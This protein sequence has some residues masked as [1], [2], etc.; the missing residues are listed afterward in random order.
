LNI[1][2]YI[3]K[4]IPLIII[5]LSIIITLVLALLKSDEEKDDISVDVPN[6]KPLLVEIVDFRIYVESAGHIKPKT[7]YPLRLDLPGKVVFLST[8]FNDNRIFNKGDTL[9]RID[10][11]DYSIARINAKFK[12]DE[13]ELEFLRQKAISS[14][15]ENELDEYKTTANVNDLAKNKPQLEKAKSLLNAAKANYRKTELDLKET[16]LVAP[17]QGRIIDGEANLGQDI[18]L[19]MY[20]G[21]IYSLDEMIIKLPL[22]IEDISILNLNHQTDFGQSISIQLDTRIGDAEYN[23]D[24]DYIGSSGSINKLSQ[25]ID[26]TAL[27]DDFSDLNIPVENNLFFNAKIYG[28]VYDRVFS[29]PNIAIHDDS[30][31]YIIEDS[32]IFKREIEILKKYDDVSIVNSGLL[33]GEVINLTKMD[34]YVDGMI[35]NMMESK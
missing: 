20:L 32:K 35:V 14:R 25:K 6:V 10:S 17:F 4:I 5:G 13:A 34:Y 9:L 23:V 15:S 28:P 18:T 3:A 16:V 31:V 2:S 12:L 30:Y 27:I 29:I 24:A 21:T 19:G 1:K 26:I 11:T 22:S 7:I 33:N 8:Y